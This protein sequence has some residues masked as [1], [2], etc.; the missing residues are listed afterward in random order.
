M[1]VESESVYDNASGNSAGASSDYFLLQCVK[2]NFWL[3]CHNDRRLVDAIPLI[4]HTAEFVICSIREILTTQ[5]EY[6]KLASKQPDVYLMNSALIQKLIDVE[7][8]ISQY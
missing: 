3:I 7:K 8:V 1:W 5:K 2:V 6:S 4:L